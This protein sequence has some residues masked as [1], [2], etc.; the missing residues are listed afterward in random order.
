M[1]FLD[2]EKT[3]EHASELLC[4][5]LV[6]AMETYRYTELRHVSVFLSKSPCF[7]Q[8]CEPRC[9]VIIVLPEAKGSR[10]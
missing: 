2:N 4:Q 7:H 5:Q 6:K 1:E 10:I 9:E 8:D 3:G